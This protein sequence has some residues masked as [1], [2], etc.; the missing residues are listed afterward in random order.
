ATGS[1]DLSL[2]K[3]GTHNARPGDEV[4]YRLDYT[5]VGQNAATGV[6]LKDVLP[7]G[8]TFITNSCGHC[9]VSGQ[10]ITWSLGTIN[11]GASGSVSF[12]AIVGANVAAGSTLQN[13]AQI[14]SAEVDANPA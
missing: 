13:W 3:T 7:G 6:Q 4:S 12:R 2:T 10:E 1:P 9:S 8:L 14:L 11:P 5:N